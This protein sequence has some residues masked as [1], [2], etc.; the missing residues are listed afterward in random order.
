MLVVDEFQDMIERF[1]EL[2]AVVADVAARGRSL[3]VPLVLASQRPNGIVREQ[4][5]ANCAIR[6]SL[7]VMQAADSIAVVGSDEAAYIDAGTPGRGV[8]D[9][10]DG[11]P[12]RF[13]SARVDP[14]EIDRLM[15][16]LLVRGK[17]EPF[18]SGRIEHG[19]PRVQ[20]RRIGLARVHASGA[21]HDGW[22]AHG[23]VPCVG[24]R[25]DQ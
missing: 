14:T 5:T 12:V 22:F 16:S 6:V 3:G 10:G 2:G 24:P 11:R 23:A 1:P 20:P 7:R 25:L 13:Q 17:D 15:R 18:T 9:A 21:G 19:L 8:V 4:V